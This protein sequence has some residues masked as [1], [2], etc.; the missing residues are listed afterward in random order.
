MPIRKNTHRYCCVSPPSSTYLAIQPNIRCAEIFDDM[1]QLIPPYTLH[2]RHQVKSTTHPAVIL[3]VK[4]WPKSDF[5][6]RSMLMCL[7]QWKLAALWGHWMMIL[8]WIRQNPI[9]LGTWS[10]YLVVWVVLVASRLIVE[11]YGT[12]DFWCEMMMWSA[13]VWM[14]VVQRPR[15]RGR[16]R[17]KSG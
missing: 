11:G 5:E 4:D 1:S 7:R 3:E 2:H 10:W 14:V 9:V 17:V 6:S 15:E 12:Y 13:E 8:N 16:R